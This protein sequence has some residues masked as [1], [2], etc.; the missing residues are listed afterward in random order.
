[1]RTIKRIHIPLNVKNTAIDWQLRLEL[2][3][4]HKQ[5]SHRR[6]GVCVC[7]CV[8]CLAFRENVLNV[9]IAYV[10]NQFYK[11]ILIAVVKMLTK[12]QIHVAKVTSHVYDIDAY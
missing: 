4:R 12:H 10:E 2:A 3:G 9:K 1:M 11:I 5:I 8:R 7:V 6:V